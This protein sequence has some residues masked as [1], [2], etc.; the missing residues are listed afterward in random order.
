M[1]SPFDS[2]L[3]VFAPWLRGAW[4]RV[5][6][7]WNKLML[8]RVAAWSTAVMVVGWVWS[9]LHFSGTAFTQ[10]SGYMDGIVVQTLGTPPGY[11]SSKFAMINT[12]VPLSECFDMLL[13]YIALI[14]TLKCLSIA[15]RAIGWL[16]S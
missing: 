1:A 6:E 4:D 16:F 15:L 12:F 9:A 10:A 11:L 8:W 13:V 3:D 14:V 7:A 5:T 2:L